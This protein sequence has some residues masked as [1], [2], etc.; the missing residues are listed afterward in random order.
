MLFRSQTS[1]D[2]LGDGPDLSLR[3]RRSRALQVLPQRLAFLVIH[4]EV[5]RAVRLQK[6]HHPNDVGMAEAGQRAG[7]V[8]EA[9]RLEAPV[10]G[11]FRTAIVDTEVGGVPIPAGANLMIVYASGNYDE[12][13]FEN[14]EHLDPCRRNSMKHLS[15]GH[16]EHY[17]LG[18]ALARAE[19]RIAVETLVDR[20][21]NIRL[22][23]QELE[24]EPSYVLHGMKT[25]HITFD[26][27]R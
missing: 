14:P 18:A 17:C 8:E 2:G 23:P 7:F 10:Q 24:F 22:A 5:G 12:S 6:V 16:G 13:Q 1:E 25:L 3:E 21:D 11:L 27:R 26:K 9:L 19:G 4:H 15:F 20:L